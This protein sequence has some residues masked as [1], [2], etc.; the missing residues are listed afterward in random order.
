MD[1]NRKEWAVSK[2]DFD[3]PPV[4]ET[5]LSIEFPKIESWRI[6]HYGLFWSSVQERFPHFNVTT[7]IPPS[8]LAGKP[9]GII[10]QPI[11]EPDARLLLIDKTETRVLQIQADRF[12]YNWRKVSD[13]DDY[14]RYERLRSEFLELWSV[15]ARFLEKS[16]LQATQA[17]EQCEVTYVNSIPQG[18]GW[19]TWAD[20]SE[21]FPYFSGEN[22]GGYLPSP[23][24]VRFSSEYDVSKS[25]ALSITLQPAQRLSDRKVVIQMTM[26]VK[27]K[28]EAASSE[29]IIAWMDESRKHI[30]SGFVD[31]TSR[32]MHALWGMKSA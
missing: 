21:V 19:S 32:K 4:I 7:P 28:P 27:G 23:K 12:G 29:S 17:I 1:S 15:F 13:S 16:E 30:V 6:P 14:P 9:P 18:D 2:I 31:F 3:R 22:S 5:A 20:L 24:V 25:A 8:A 26:T 10:L 11:L